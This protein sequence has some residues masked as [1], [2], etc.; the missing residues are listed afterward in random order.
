MS[1]GMSG[2]GNS[3]IMNWRILSNMP[4]ALHLTS[5]KGGQMRA[6]GSP[7]SYYA[8]TQLN[9]AS[10]FVA[11]VLLTQSELL[12]VKTKLGLPLYSFIWLGK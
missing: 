2:Y 7:W 12:Y 8:Y 1:A 9:N 11:N 5:G 10:F 6:K 3:E 4:I